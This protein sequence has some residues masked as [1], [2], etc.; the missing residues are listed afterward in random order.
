MPFV[1]GGRPSIDAFGDVLRGAERA[2]ASIIEVGIPFSDP[3]ADGPVIAQAMDRAIRD[4]VTPAKVFDAVH[5]ARDSLS[6]GL[7]AMVSYSVVRRWGGDAEFAARAAQAG[8]DG[9]IVPDL[10]VEES[11]ELQAA[12]SDAGLSLAMLV[13]PTTEPERAARIVEA[14]TGF[15]YVLARAGVTGEGGQ[16]PEM[17]ARIADLRELTSLPI[18]VGFGVSSAAHVRGVVQTADAAIV[19][20]ALVRRAE[21]GESVEQVVGELAGGLA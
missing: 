6:A 8:F 5:A 20:S 9:L 1:V 13:G 10:P 4:G 7:V 14:S 2:G 15:V 21:A 11:A 17:A 3:I 18:A 16:M 19:G 12:A